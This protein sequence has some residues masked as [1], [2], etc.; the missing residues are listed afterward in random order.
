[1][2]GATT[3]RADDRGAALGRL[4][5]SYISPSLTWAGTL[6]WLRALLGPAGVPTAVK[7]VQTAGD[8]VRAVRA[9]AR[10]VVLSNHGGRSLDTA[11]AA[12]LVLLELQRCCPAVFA[13][14]EVYVDGGVARGTDVFKALCL[15]A[16]AVGVGRGV[17]YALGWGEEGVRRY[18]QSEYTNQLIPP[19][20]FFSP[21]FSFSFF[22]QGK[23]GW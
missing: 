10:A 1:M 3:P 16:R 8:A 14:A 9:G 7:G 4:M 5:A 12:V 18:L 15:G 23:L 6:P 11:P 20:I 19:P 2:A 21:F 17:L 22:L 13:R